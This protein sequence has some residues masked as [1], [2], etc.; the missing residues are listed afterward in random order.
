MCGDAHDGPP[1]DDDTWSAQECGALHVTPIDDLREHI[2][3]KGT[4]WCH[5]DHDEENDIYVHHSMDGR[6]A[7]EDTGRK[8]H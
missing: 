7:Y 3:D 8:M 5:P 1:N 4:C 2:L 6:E